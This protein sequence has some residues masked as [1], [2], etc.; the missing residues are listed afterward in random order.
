MD[1]TTTSP[2]R[3]K[4]SKSQKKLE[5][6]LPNSTKSPAKR[7]NSITECR[8]LSHP[9]LTIQLVQNPSRGALPAQ[10]ETI[11]AAPRKRSRDLFRV[12]VIQE[13]ETDQRPFKLRRVLAR[14]LGADTLDLVIGGAAD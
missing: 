4:P 13:R 7:N 14:H 3:T 9:L 2:N 11:L 6:S 8:T 10:K 12:P 5:Q 1:I